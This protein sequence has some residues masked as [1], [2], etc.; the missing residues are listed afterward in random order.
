[1]AAFARL[2][3]D[4]ADVLSGNSEALNGKDD[5]VISKDVRGNAESDALAIEELN[6]LPQRQPFEEGIVVSQY[7]DGLLQAGEPI[8]LGEFGG[9]LRISPNTR[10]IMHTHPFFKDSDAALCQCSPAATNR[11]NIYKGPGDH[12]VVVNNRVPNYF[13][14]PTGNAI[15]VVELIGGKIKTR[16]VWQ[17]K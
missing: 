7:E 13:R 1:M 6:S 15:R 14:T 12:L 16:T 3:N 2:F 11:A 4:E 9:S 8:R 5:A 10:F 17:R